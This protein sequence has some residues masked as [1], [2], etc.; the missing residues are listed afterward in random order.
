[1]AKD[2]R[3]SEALL[4]A[5][6]KGAPKIDERL[7]ADLAAVLEKVPAHDVWLNGQPKP[8]FLKA[9]F[10]LDDLAANASLLT[11]VLAILDKRGGIAGGLRVFPRGIPWPGEFVVD[12]QIGARHQL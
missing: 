8:D 3:G 9:S 5:Y 11:D 7:V 12:V 6:K 4:A 2:I 10:V 1:M